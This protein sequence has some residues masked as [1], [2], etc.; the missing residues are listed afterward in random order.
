MLE[1]RRQQETGL[2]ENVRAP[3][4]LPTRVPNPLL[5]RKGPWTA[6]S[7]L[8]TRWQ[9]WKEKPASHLLRRQ[10]V[11]G[12]P[13]PGLSL[14]EWYV[15][16]PGEEL[17]T[18]KAAFR[19]GRGHCVRTGFVGREAQVYLGAARSCLCEAPAGGNFTR[20]QRTSGQGNEGTRG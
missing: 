1:I 7:L 12:S 16:R 3:S 18:R 5:L 2:E 15:D 14:Y 19:E 10:T 9:N 11:H 6:Q 4:P 20:T 17:P 13:G 8:E